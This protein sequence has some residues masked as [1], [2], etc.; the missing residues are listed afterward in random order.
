MWACFRSALEETR[1]EAFWKN[2]QKSAIKDQQR[3]AESKHLKSFYIFLRY[4]CSIF[5]VSL[6]Y[7]ECQ[8]LDNPNLDVNGDDE[9]Q[10]RGLSQKDF[11]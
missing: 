8:D 7:L 3:A 2:L 10:A 1:G 6:Q 9:T 5:A 4:V 11:V